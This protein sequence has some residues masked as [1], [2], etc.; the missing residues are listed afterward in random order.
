[1]YI[2]ATALHIANVLWREINLFNCSF[3]HTAGRTASKLSVIHHILAWQYV[4]C[5]KGD[6]ASQ[7]EMTI[8]DVRTP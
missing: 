4:H 7:W 5:C 8:W 1:M 6:T 2:T 3:P